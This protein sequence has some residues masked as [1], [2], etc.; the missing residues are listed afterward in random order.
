MK[1]VH[2]ES[3]CLAFPKPLSLAIHPAFIFREEI[4]HI[5][6]FVRKGDGCSSLLGLNISVGKLLAIVL[7]IYFL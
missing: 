4:N 6:C 7:L 5:L 3:F 1:L 2:C